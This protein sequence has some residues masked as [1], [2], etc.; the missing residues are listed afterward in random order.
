MDVT[1]IELLTEIIKL[2]S[3]QELLNFRVS[4]NPIIHNHGQKTF[5]ALP[6]EPRFLSCMAFSRVSL[7]L[8]QR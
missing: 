8:V 5:S 4:F 3:T 6:Y 1:Q 7:L 2:L